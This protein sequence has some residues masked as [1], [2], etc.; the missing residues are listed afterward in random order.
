M[1]RDELLLAA[2]A[3]GAVSTADLVQATGLNEPTCRR[4]LRHLIDE[5]YVWSP[6]RGRWRLTDSGRTIAAE[7]PA[8]A[9]AGTA[10]PPPTATRDRPR[11]AAHED[12]ALVDGDRSLSLSSTLVWVLAGGLGVV[13]LVAYLLSADRVVVP[14]PYP[15]TAPTPAVYDPPWPGFIATGW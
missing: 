15:E 8:L 10:E 11:D 6:E 1:T 5:G 2:L 7:P 4:G 13:G 12:G 3:A 9:S 14:V